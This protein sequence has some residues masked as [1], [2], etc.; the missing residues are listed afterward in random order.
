MCFL[1]SKDIKSKNA[2]SIKYEVPTK[3][4]MYLKFF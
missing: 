2:Y 3:Q 1:N 4:P